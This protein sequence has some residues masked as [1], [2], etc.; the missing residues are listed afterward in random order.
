MNVTGS[1]GPIPK[2]RL[3]ISHERAGQRQTAPGQHGPQTLWSER[4]DETRDGQ[5]RQRAAP[6]TPLQAQSSMGRQQG[7]AGHVSAPLAVAQDA[8]GRDGE[9]R[10]ARG[11][12]ETPER[13]PTQA[14]PDVRRGVRQ[15]P[16]TATGQ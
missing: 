9:H 2:S 12:L 4:P 16:A 8:M 14:D 6:R 10:F 11:A 13:H 3:F 1:R 15:A 7:I 5:R